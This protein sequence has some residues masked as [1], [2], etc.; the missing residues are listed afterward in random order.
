MG[1]VDI[2]Q[3]LIIGAF[4]A[5]FGSYATLFAHRIPINESCFGRYFGSKS[6]CPNCNKTLKTRELIP[7]INWIVTKGECSQ[8]HFKIPRSHLFLEASITIL[9]MTAFYF[10]GFGEKFIVTCI[11]ITASAVAIVVDFK[12]RNIPNQVLFVILLIGLAN[13]VLQDQNIIDSVFWGTFGIICSTIFY[14]IF[15]FDGKN[16]LIINQ[17]QAFSYTKFIAICSICLK[18]ID[19][20]LYFSCILL[21]LS[22]FILLGKFVPK[23]SPRLGASLIIPFI[24]LL[25][26]SPI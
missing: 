5:V 15:F 13:R 8:C 7:L 17:D 26:K 4:G 16:S 1:I 25:I 23:R 11:I 2:L 24:W 14:K 10:L 22:L 9:F 6:R 21:I 3:I 19:F 18:P 20:A 12:H